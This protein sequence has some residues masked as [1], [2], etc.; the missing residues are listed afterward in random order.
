[1]SSSLLSSELE[2]SS[3]VIVLGLVCLLDLF[4]QYMCWHW[5]GQQ[6]LTVSVH[7]CMTETGSYSA[8]SGPS[9]HIRKTVYS[10]LANRISIIC[11]NSIDQGK[12]SLYFW[13]YFYK[14]P[15]NSIFPVVNNRLC[16]ALSFFIYL[17]ALKHIHWNEYVKGGLFRAFR[18]HQIN[19]DLFISRFLP[20]ETYSVFSLN[21][22]LCIEQ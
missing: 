10:T 19:H 16:T 9:L 15:G 8:K 1:M 5:V 2:S 4:L 14:L 3:S 12:K 22:R 13:Q 11:F 18:Y 6:H 21:K 20:V 17:K 7:N